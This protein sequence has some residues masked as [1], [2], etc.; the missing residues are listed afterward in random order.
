[1]KLLPFFLTSRFYTKL[2]TLPLPNPSHPQP[3]PSPNLT[4]YYYMNPKATQEMVRFIRRHRIEEYPTLRAHHWVM[5][6][7]PPISALRKALQVYNLGLR[8]YVSNKVVDSMVG[9]LCPGGCGVS[10]NQ[11][12]AGFCNGEV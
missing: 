9:Y 7:K 5:R 1:M 2:S 10:F 3:T 4:S 12:Q 6:K 8:N 11:A